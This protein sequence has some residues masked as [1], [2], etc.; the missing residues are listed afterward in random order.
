[1]SNLMRQSERFRRAADVEAETPITAGPPIMRKW[2]VRRADYL[3]V[4]PTD[5]DDIV[6]E[7]YGMQL[8]RYTNEGDGIEPALER[9]SYEYDTQ[10]EAITA[11]IDLY[12]RDLQTAQ[13]LRERDAAEKAEAGLRI[14]ERA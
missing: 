5:L 8:T 2:W 11:G 10:A 4:V 9:Q 3:A 7:V 14:L 13:A 6:R 1:M 12:R